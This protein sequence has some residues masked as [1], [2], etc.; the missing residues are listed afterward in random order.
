MNRAC[1]KDALHE[2]AFGGKGCFRSGTA[3][4]RAGRFRKTLRVEKDCGEKDAPHREGLPPS[5]IRFLLAAGSLD[6]QESLPPRR[7]SRRV[8]VHQTGKTYSGRW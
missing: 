4:Q 1:V 3:C 8:S 7:P 6:S 5:Q 2:R